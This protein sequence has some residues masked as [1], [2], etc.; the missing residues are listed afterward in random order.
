[1]LQNLYFK[2]YLLL[3]LMVFIAGYKSERSSEADCGVGPAHRA[4]RRPGRGRQAGGAAVGDRV[5][6]QA[7]RSRGQVRHTPIHAREVNTCSDIQCTDYLLPLTI[8]I[9]NMEYCLSFIIFE[10]QIV[11]Y[12]F[13]L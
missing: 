6:R 8:Y 11:S 1:M 10:N 4:A 9:D 12:S 13:I 2:L 7:G 3:L 5:A